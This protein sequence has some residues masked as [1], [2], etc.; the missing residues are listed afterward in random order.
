MVVWL[1]NFIM[2]IS[3]PNM[4]SLHVRNLVLSQAPDEQVWQPSISAMGDLYY[5]EILLGYPT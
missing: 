1:M 2:R 5:S 3:S 4:L